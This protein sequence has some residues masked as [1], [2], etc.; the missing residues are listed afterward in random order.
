[1]IIKITLKKTRTCYIRPRKACIWFMLVSQSSFM[2]LPVFYLLWSHLVSHKQFFM[3]FFSLVLFKRVLIVTY[4]HI[5][6]ESILQIRKDVLFDSLILVL[7]SLWCHAVIEFIFSIIYNIYNS[8]DHFP[9]NTWPHQHIDRGCMTMC[10]TVLTGRTKK[11]TW[12]DEKKKKTE[13][14]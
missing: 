12:N 2:S 11:P 6:Q 3:F 10:M 1:M 14:G 5:I 13:K 4:L 8:L 7:N 9:H